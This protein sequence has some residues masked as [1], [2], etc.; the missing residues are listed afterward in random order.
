MIDPNIGKT[1]GLRDMHAMQVM[2]LMEFIELAIELSALTGDRDIVKETEAAA[3]DLVRLFGGNGV[4]IE[5]E[6]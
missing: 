2:N 6:D 3:D 4:R 5:V 1:L